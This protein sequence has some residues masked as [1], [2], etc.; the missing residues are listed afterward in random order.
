M[1]QRTYVCDVPLW[2]VVCVC[3]CPSQVNTTIAPEANIEENDITVNSTKEV[4]EDFSL[5]HNLL[6]ANYPFYQPESLDDKQ[7]CYVLKKAPT[8]FVTL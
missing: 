8:A 5:T 2:C 4:V 7:R 3:V 6:N 1:A